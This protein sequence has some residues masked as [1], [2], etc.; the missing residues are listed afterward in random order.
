[1]I[2]LIGYI[3]LGTMLGSRYILRTPHTTMDI[4][5]LRV[6]LLVLTVPVLFKYSMYLVIGPWYDVLLKWKKI[7][8]ARDG[9]TYE[10]L[11]SVLIPAWNEEVGI[12]TTI[13]SLLYNDYP[14]IELV[15][16]NDGSTDNSDTLLRDYIKSYYLS[17]RYYESHIEITYR[18]VPNGGKGNALNTAIGLSHGDILMSIDADCLVQPD[19]I[20]NFVFHFRDPL[21]MAAVGNVKIGNPH[22][23]WGVIQYLEF[24][25]S[26]YFK[27]TDSLCNS[28]YIIGGAGGAFRRE[29]FADVGYYNSSNITEDIDLS[30]R[31]QDAGMKIAYAAD[32]VILTEGA[33]T[34]SSLAKQRLRWKRGRLETFIEHRHLFFSRKRH[35]NKLL[36]WYVLPLALLGD[37]QLVFEIVLLLFLYIY[38]YL[39]GDFSGFISGLALAGFI[40]VNIIFFGDS[41]RRDRS[42]LL[43]APIGWFLL[44]PTTLIE[45]HALYQSIWGAIR[46]K[47]LTWQRWE[48]TGVTGHTLAT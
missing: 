36:T 33:S 39:T 41:D 17:D 21:V 4:T 27:K 46:K 38:S 13:E 22:S 18:Y 48:R 24:L 35:H 10:P 1:M 42:F 7:Q 2:Y 16:V 8:A 20:R 28:I 32:A 43:L 19:A 44:Y 29:V 11:V 6:V 5:A 45:I 34:P 9:R 3:A 14:N 40:F 30:V 12:L 25:F 31:I 23:Y 47:E 26:F 15:I 37:C